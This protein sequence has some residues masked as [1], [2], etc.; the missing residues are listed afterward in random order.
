[1][2]QFIEKLDKIN[3]PNVLREK[4]GLDNLYRDGVYYDIQNKVGLTGYVDFLRKN[5]FPEN[6]KIIYG[7]DRYNRF[8]IS[9]LI[10]VRVNDSVRDVAFTIFKRYSDNP[11]YFT[12][13]LYLYGSSNDAIYIIDDEIINMPKQLILLFDIIKKGYGYY[14]YDENEYFYKY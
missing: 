6:K 2:D 3:F 12:N 10:N 4:I 14:L 5:D 11:T 8:F 7:S 1:M 9:F 13:G